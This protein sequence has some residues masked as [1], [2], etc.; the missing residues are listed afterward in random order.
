MALKAMQLRERVGRGAAGKG[1]RSD[2][3]EAASAADGSKTRSNAPSA[4][5]TDGVGRSFKRSRRRCNRAA[6]GPMQP[7]AETDADPPM[8]AEEMTQDQCEDMG[9]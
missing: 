4:A 5:M 2:P 3:G 1:A 8:N 6:C 9:W 7:R